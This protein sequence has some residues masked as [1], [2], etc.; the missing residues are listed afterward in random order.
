MTKNQALKIADGSVVELGRL[1]GITHNA[2]SQWNDK[3]IPKLR[4]YQVNEIILK[5]EQDA[6]LEEA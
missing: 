3:K 2:V 5:R 4:E 6:Q 1:L